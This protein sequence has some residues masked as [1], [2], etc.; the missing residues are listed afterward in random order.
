MTCCCLLFVVRCLL[1]VACCG[2]LFVVRRL[3]L[4]EGLGVVVNGVLCVV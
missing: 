4:F 2:V 1:C 3:L